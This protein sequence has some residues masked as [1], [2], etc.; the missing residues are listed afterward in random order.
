MPKSGIAGSDSNSMLRVWGNCQAFP[1]WLHRFTFPPAMYEC[2]S[3]SATDTSS[4][5]GSM[6]PMAQV[7]G[8]H[9]L[10]TKITRVLSWFRLLS[11]RASFH[12]T[13]G[14]STIPPGGMCCFQ[15]PER[16][17]KPCTSFLVAG[18][19]SYNISSFTLKEVSQHAPNP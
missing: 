1:W 14:L 11:K 2:S 19:L 5:M 17:S 13:L 8:L 15:N 12:I 18:S 7:A 16:L 6:G 9:I 4:S 10:Q 3:F